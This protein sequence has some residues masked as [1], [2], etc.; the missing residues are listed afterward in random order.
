MLFFDLLIIYNIGFSFISK[1]LNYNYHIKALYEDFFCKEALLSPF[2]ARLALDK[3][4]TCIQMRL[5]DRSIKIGS[6]LTCRKKDSCPGWISNQ[7]SLL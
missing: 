2:Y 5:K 4:T 6:N 7:I 3:C 1:Y